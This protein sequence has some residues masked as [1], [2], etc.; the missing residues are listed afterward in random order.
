M[1]VFLLGYLGLSAI[2]KQSE[3]H[4]GGINGKNS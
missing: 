1:V 2:A 3:K 4:W